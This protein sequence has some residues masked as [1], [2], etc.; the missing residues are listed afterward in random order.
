[1]VCHQPATDLR[2]IWEPKVNPLEA[3]ATQEG[4]R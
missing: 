4:G 3:A 1:M 2:I